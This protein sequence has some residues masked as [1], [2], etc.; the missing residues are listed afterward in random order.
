MN[1]W[2]ICWEFNIGRS[3]FDVERSTFV[4]LVDQAEHVFHVVD[5]GR[6]ADCP[7]CGT[8]GA[9]SEYLTVGCPVSQFDALA[10][11]TEVDRVFAND[12]TAADS[13]YADL[14][15]GA[16]ANQTFTAMDNLIFAKLVGLTENFNEAFGGAARC[17]FF[18][19]MMQLKHFRF[20]LLSEDGGGL[21][22]QI[23]QGIDTYGV[24]ASP[25]DRD[26]A[27]NCL[28][29][30]FALRVGVPGSADHE[31]Q[32]VCCRKLGD[33][34]SDFMEAEVDDGVAFGNR[35]GRDR[36]LRRRRRV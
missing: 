22:G 15:A 24:I 4:A 32:R 28:E 7:V 5:A 19:V 17:I 20:V 18:V 16:C 26:C 31:R 23:V 36:R 21:T 30:R 34:R 10:V 27:F 12:I 9:L 8:Y 25:D 1:G 6:F 11:P 13:V 33:G 14:F 2:L 35:S 29:D 3:K